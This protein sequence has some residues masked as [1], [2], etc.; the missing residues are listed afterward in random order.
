MVT[1]INL[2]LT[3]VYILVSGIVGK[4]VPESISE[5][6]YIWESFCKKHG[7]F[8]IAYIFSI[9]CFVTAGLLFVPWIE[10]T[11][12]QWQFIC[13]IGC[14]GIIAAGITPFFKKVDGIIHYVGGLI[15][16]SSG[17]VWFIVMGYIPLL[18]H[19]TL[20]WIICTFI[21][22]KAFVLWAELLFLG[23]LLVTL[24]K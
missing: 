17:I 16:L 20:S 6:S 11:P 15:A 4:K 22:K 21:K 13:F 10:H 12:D 24:L 2:I 5:T 14:I 19:T 9:Y 8:H 3:T 1:L 23:S 7:Q 18:I